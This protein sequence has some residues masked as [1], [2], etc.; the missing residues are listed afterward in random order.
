MKLVVVGLACVLLIL[1][2]ITILLGIVRTVQIAHKPQQK[3]FLGGIVPKVLPN[4]VYKGT[5]TGLK[6]T[7]V[8]KRFDASN[9][10]GINVF[11][12]GNSG[13]KKYPFKTYVG[14]GVADKNLKVIK[15]D[16]S[17]N[18]DHWWLRF[19]LD[20]VVEVSPDKYLGKV[21]ITVIPG[22]PF[23]LGYFR[24]EK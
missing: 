21:H 12:D 15:I 1:V 4:G 19:I 24:L 10:S 2:L 6:T 17:A 20:E 3:E 11:K 9:S 14:E 13:S 22:L 16:Y 7:W 23:S 8:G 18:K 5:V